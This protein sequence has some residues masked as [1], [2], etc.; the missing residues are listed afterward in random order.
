MLK[1]GDFSSLAQVSIKTLR[2]YDERGLLSP[3]H[4]DPETGYRYY[5]A[6]Q[7]S[8]LH[9]ILALKDFGF[10]LEQIATCLEE[11]VTAEQ[12]RGMLVLRRPNSTCA[13]RKNSIVSADFKAAFGSLNRRHPCHKRS[14]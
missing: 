6:S 12:M 7:L 4:V 8:R 1:I 10:S 11:K 3:A 5:S 2:Y 13:L 14:F 9:H